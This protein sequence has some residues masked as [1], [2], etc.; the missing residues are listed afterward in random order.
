[1]NFRNDNLPIDYKRC[2]KIFQEVLS[3]KLST[4]T[5]KFLVKKKIKNDAHPQT[6]WVLY[7]T[8]NEKIT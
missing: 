6:S 5:E 4:K 2:Y 3:S 1:M 8:I 7:E